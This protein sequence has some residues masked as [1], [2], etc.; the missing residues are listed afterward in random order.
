VT[1]EPVQ[2]ESTG[3]ETTAETKEPAGEREAEDGADKTGSA[4]PEKKQPE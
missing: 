1:P 3:A 2:S 4:E